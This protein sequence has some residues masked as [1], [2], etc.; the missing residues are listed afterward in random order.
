VRCLE[1]IA[2][3]KFNTKREK[4]TPKTTKWAY[5]IIGKLGGWKDDN[6]QRRAGP[7]TLQ[8]GLVKFY[9]MFEGW[10]LNKKYG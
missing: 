3:A 10:M 2:A 5:G 6:K 9:E 4:Y 1:K 7:I 8:K